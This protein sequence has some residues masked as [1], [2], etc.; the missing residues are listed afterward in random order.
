MESNTMDPISSTVCSLDSSIA[1]IDLLKHQ[2]KQLQEIQNAKNE[3]YYGCRIDS[4]EIVTG[5]LEDLHKMIEKLDKDK[6]TLT[7]IGDKY[8]NMKDGYVRNSMTGK[9]STENISYFE[10][11]GK[12]FIAENS[13]VE[14]LSIEGFVLRYFDIHLEE[15]FKKFD[16]VM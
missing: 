7:K 2:Y 6:D 12:K 8:K 14:K 9:K 15:V 10:E 11:D 13:D 16:E 5:I 3:K 1:K 4:D